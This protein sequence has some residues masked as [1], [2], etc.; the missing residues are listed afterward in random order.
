MPVKKKEVGLNGMTM[1]GSRG[2]RRHVIDAEA[3]KV[4]PM[5]VQL[6]KRRQVDPG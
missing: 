3:K 4:H 6:N 1:E 5:V 2:P